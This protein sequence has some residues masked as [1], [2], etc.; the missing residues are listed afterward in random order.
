M[1]ILCNF[2]KI[3]HCDG[4][5][6]SPLFSVAY[7]NNLL[8]A[9]QLCMDGNTKVFHVQLLLIFISLC[10]FFC[11]NP[12]YTIQAHCVETDKQYARVYM[13]R[14][15]Y[16]LTKMMI[17]RSSTMRI[18]LE[19]VIQSLAI[20]LQNHHTLFRKNYLYRCILLS[21]IIFKDFIVMSFRVYMQL[22]ACV[23]VCVC[24]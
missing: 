23:L 7:M 1:W 14:Y 24:V 6:P 5:F 10:R 12:K 22:G 4:K 13:Y 11:Y 2:V 3:S 8:A 16:R 9:F 21:N 15:E 18:A 17:W 20:R 19:K